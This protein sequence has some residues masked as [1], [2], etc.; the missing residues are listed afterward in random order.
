VIWA[1]IEERI[2]AVS[3]RYSDTSDDPKEK[4]NGNLMRT[5]RVKFAAYRAT[6]AAF[7]SQFRDSFAQMDDQL[8]QL[9]QYTAKLQR[10]TL[11]FRNAPT[12][13]TDGLRLER[14]DVAKDRCESLGHYNPTDSV[15]GKGRLSLKSLGDKIYEEKAYPRYHGFEDHLRRMEIDRQERIAAD[16]MK[17]DWKLESANQAGTTFG[18][19][20]SK[21]SS[22]LAEMNQKLKDFIQ[23]VN[24]VRSSNVLGPEQLKDVLAAQKQVTEDRNELLAIAYELDTIH[25]NLA[26]R[27][28]SDE[29]AVRSNSASHVASM[30]KATQACLDELNSRTSSIAQT[31]AIKMDPVDSDKACASCGEIPVSPYAIPKFEESVEQLKGKNK[32]GTGSMSPDADRQRQPAQ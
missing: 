16:K 6:S 21:L 13:G 25:Q 7:S 18:A 9:Q 11:E 22:A 28:D 20:Y 10:E 19:S 23:N 2:H 4:S 14:L 12:N 17:A 26:S 32:W 29:S 30:K 31:S 27:S 24:G 5:L 8:G 15:S 1:A 3:S